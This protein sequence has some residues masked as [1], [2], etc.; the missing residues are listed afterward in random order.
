MIDQRVIGGVPVARIL[1]V[2]ALSDHSCWSTPSAP[3]TLEAWWRGTERPSR[4]APSSC[5]TSRFRTVRLSRSSWCHWTSTRTC[6]R[7]KTWLASTR[8]KPKSTAA[9]E[10]RGRS[11]SR[12][13]AT[14]F[15]SRLSLTAQRQIANASAWRRQHRPAAAV[16]VEEEVAK[17]LELLERYPHAGVAVQWAGSQN[18]RCLSLAGRDHILIY[19]VRLRLREVRVVGLVASRARRRP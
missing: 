14:G 7:P 1:E 4:T 12:T 16:S 15:V 17:A 8:Q 18:V 10:S 19:R 2:Q 11:S 6:S 9:K 13:S 3:H 5:A